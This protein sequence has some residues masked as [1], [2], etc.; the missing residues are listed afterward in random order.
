MSN[1]I[2]TPGGYSGYGGNQMGQ[3]QF[4]NN[5]HQKQFVAP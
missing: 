4:E 2:Q 3:Q 5:G 1:D